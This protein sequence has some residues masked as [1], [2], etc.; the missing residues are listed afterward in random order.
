MEKKTTTHKA[1][2]F[3]VLLLVMGLTMISLHLITFLNAKPV[4]ALSPN[5]AT[6]VGPNCRYGAT[7][8]A[9]DTTPYIGDLGAGWYL[10]FSD[11]K[12]NVDPGNAS[13]Y[14]PIIRIRERRDQNGNFLGRWFIKNGDG[15]EGTEA[16]AYIRS[17]VTQLPGSL[18]LIGNE[19]DR[20]TQDE[21]TPEVYA[22]A[23]H[24]IAYWIRNT[25]PTARIAISGLVEVTPLRLAYLDRIWDA[26]LQKYQ[27]PIPVDV[28]NMHIY[29]IPEVGT[30]GVTP[31][32]ASIPVGINLAQ[33]SAVPKR[34]SGGQASLCAANDVYCFAEHDNMDIFEQQIIDMRTWMKNH[35]QQNKPLILSEYSLLWPYEVDGNTCF[36]Q[37]EYGNC[38]TPQRV[39]TFMENSFNKLESLKD[40]SLGY[41]LDENRLVQ[42]WMWFSLYTG[43]PD[44]AG[45]ASDLLQL[46]D[47]NY[48][49]TLMGATFYDYVASKTTQADFAVQHTSGTPAFSDGGGTATATLNV[50]FLNA[51]NLQVGDPVE[52]TFYEDAARTNPIGSVT[53]TTDI[54]GCTIYRYNAEVE[55]AS[56]T[57][58]V[59]QYWVKIDSSNSFP[60]KDE[61]NN[62][63]TGY[64][65]IDPT[66][67]F[68][69]IALK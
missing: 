3:L 19:I 15:F 68:L 35:N 26:Y 22:D 36:L 52:I 24:D 20:L 65:I 16:E 6:A 29:I 45:G 10:N 64:V 47:S 42:Q 39:S 2:Y 14:V 40:P 63:A 5:E 21:I 30:D 61:Q 58:G 54:Y 27:A 67:V 53:T 7:P 50:Q 13:A 43:H 33:T 38:F 59:H 31:S 11:Q 51:G 57:P 18:W 41:P 12:P 49:Y 44:L 37:D 28:W 34:E 9:S 8:L 1:F 48:S 25:D 17:R 32:A 46:N 55:W 66:Q 62:I 60:E 56:L 4:Q 69:P 23:F